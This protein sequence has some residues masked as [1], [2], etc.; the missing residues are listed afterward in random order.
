MRP[1]EPIPL[2]EI[3]AARERLA[4]TALRTPLIPLEVDS[5]TAIYL[6]LENLQPIGSFKIRGAGNAMIK[7]RRDMLAGGVYTA[8]AGNM[9][10]GVAWNAREMGISCHVVV[11]DSAPKNKLEA[12]ERLGAQIV[13]VSYDD[14]WNVIVTHR[15]P[16]LD[17]MF[18]HPVSNPDVIAGNGTI[19]LEIFDDLP[20]VQTVL[21]PYGGGGLSCGIASSLRELAPE[22]KVY[23]CEIETAAPFAASLAL[24]EAAE[25]EHTPSFI[26]GIGG[27][28][29]LEEMWPMART[30]LAGSLVSTLEK[31]AAAI[32]LLVE[33]ARIIA[34]GAGATPVAAALEGEWGSGNVVCVVSGGNIDVAKLQTILR[35]GIP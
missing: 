25:T 29:V 10:Q 6:K 8:S 2:A 9:A 7:A 17:G 22:A 13:K 15:F 14:W 31:V 30:L 27:K 33:R 23:A 34:E 1:L 21:V 3:E 4:G 18:I 5:P 35:G 28:S 19:G 32:K 24:G 20:D 11:P 26:D 12:I 16:G